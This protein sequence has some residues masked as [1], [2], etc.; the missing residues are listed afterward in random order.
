MAC[1]ECITLTEAG[2]TKGDHIHQVMCLTPPNRLL[3]VIDE[4]EFDTYILAWGYLL[5]E[6]DLE[7]REARDYL[8]ILP[9]ITH[10]GDSK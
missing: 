8:T 5:F 3:I 7:S 9:I 6:C 1:K 10:L 2:R 4:E